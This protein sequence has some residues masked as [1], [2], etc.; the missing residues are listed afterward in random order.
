MSRAFEET[1]HF[2]MEHSWQGEGTLKDMGT[3]R[4]PLQDSYGKVLV[5]TV[6]ACEPELV[7]LVFIQTEPGMLFSFF[8]GPVG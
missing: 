2:P 7:T 1:R 3:H 8:P 4:S 5:L 6:P